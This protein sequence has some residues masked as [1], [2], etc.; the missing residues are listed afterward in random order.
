MGRGAAGEIG[1]RQGARRLL[2]AVRGADPAT[3]IVVASLAALLFAYWSLFSLGARFG[4]EKAVEYW[5]FRPTDNAPL[6]VLVLSG[7]LLYRRWY[8]LR[9]LPR[10]TA[11]TPWIVGCV[12][13]AAALHVW[14][15]YTR[16]DDLK[17]FSLVLGLSGVV[18]ATWGRAGLRAVWLPLFFLLFAIPIPAPLLLAVVFKLQLWTAAFAGFLLYSL[19]IPALVS[20]DQIFRVTQ[21]FQVI[22]GCSGIRSITTLTMLT[23]LM[24]DLFGRR[25]WHAV[26]LLVMAPLIAFFLNGFRVLTLILNPHSEV[27]AIHN[28]QGIVILLIGLLMVYGLDV[29]IERFAGDRM[30]APWRRPAPSASPRPFS[31]AFALGALSVFALSTAASAL[32]TPVW[33]DESP[34]PRVLHERVDAVLGAWPFEKVE[35]DYAFQGST[36]YREIVHRD[37]VLDAGP[38]TLFIATADLG[39]RGGSLLSPTTSMPGSGWLV[40]ESREIRVPGVVGPVDERVVEKRKQRLLVHHWYAGRSGLAMETWRSLAAIDRSP[41]RRANLPYVVRLE[42]PIAGRDEA[43][44]V[45]AEARLARL[46]ELVAPLLAELDAIGRRAAAH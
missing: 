39:Q 40:R 10:T 1:S 36:R 17:I 30:P 45:E 42:T 34:L 3:W 20:G 14:A 44:R 33:E 27:I 12:L 21:A 15:V 24:I 43:S 46:R 29:L 11:P 28:L 6:V 35:R 16:A 7:W 32:W 26:I 38:V 22:E 13:G 31:R 9:A 25:G 19:G 5:L 18:L 41:A 2:D 23:I 37:Y 8:R 4:F